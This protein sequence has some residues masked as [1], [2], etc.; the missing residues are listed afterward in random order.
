MVSAGEV[1]RRVEEVYA[2]HPW[3]RPPRHVLVILDEIV[4]DA[5]GARLRF[6]GLQPSWRR[7]T[8]IVSWPLLRRDTLVHETLHTYGCGERCAWLLAPR[9]AALRERRPPRVRREVR[10]RVC[11]GGPG[12]PYE[13]LH[14]RLGGRLVH[15]V[16]EG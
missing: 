1:R 14:R 7:D 6:S 13:E 3:L 9:L 10:Y 12:C 11:R 4:L 15:L 8:V 5:P 16:L 2:R